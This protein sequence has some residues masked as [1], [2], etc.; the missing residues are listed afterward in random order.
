MSG[1]DMRF[2]VPPKTFR[3]DG[4]IMQRIRQWVPNR[5]TGDSKSQSAKST[6]TTPRSI[7]FATVGRRETLAAGNCEDWHAAL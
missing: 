7:Q 2:Q 5:R 1:K 6:A 3:L 4:W